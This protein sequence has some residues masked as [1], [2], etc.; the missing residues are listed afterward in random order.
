MPIFNNAKI[1]L[2]DLKNI[3][4]SDYKLFLSIISAFMLIFLIRSIL[5]L[6]DSIFA[7][8]EYPVQRILFMVS[9]TCLIIGLEIGFTKI[10]FSIIDS[11]KTS[12][13]NIFN[14]FHLLSKYIQGL[15]YFYGILLLSII[16]AFIFL[17]FQ[18]GGDLFSIIYQS[19]E[20]PYY[21]ELIYSYLNLKSLFIL[22]LLL[23]VPAIYVSIR[24]LFWSY[25]VIDQEVGGYLAIKQ[26]LNLTKNKVQEIICYLCFI[27]LFNLVG[28]LSIIGICFTI[29][30]TYIFL[31]KYYRLIIN[32]Y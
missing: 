26:S 10:I 22:V 23:I 25:L 19:M 31:C 6:L 16:P 32:N 5:A 14:Y 20:D 1:I 8:D 11:K 27:L 7:I 17:Y 29:P 4:R 18:Y 15:L 2:N 13:N 30:L 21:Q 3:Y 9:S 24:L 28:L 12:I